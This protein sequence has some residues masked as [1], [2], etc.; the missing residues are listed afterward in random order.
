MFDNFIESWNLNKTKAVL[1]I[2][3][4]HAMCN[5]DNA[6]DIND[7]L[8]DSSI[9]TFGERLANSYVLNYYSICFVPLSG[10]SG[11]AHGKEKLRMI[12][13][14]KKNSLE[15]YLGEKPYPFAF[16]DL[17]KIKENSFYMNPFYYEYYK[18]KWGKIFS[19][20]FFIKNMYPLRYNN[21]N[22]NY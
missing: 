17:A 5:P 4:Y 20:V 12:P 10:I 18:G 14:C 15:Q 6:E 11:L 3:A 9:K 1:L 19:G 16:V 8:K 22:L 21:L 2:S 7:K 13:S